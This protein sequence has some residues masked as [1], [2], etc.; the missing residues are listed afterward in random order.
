MVVIEDMEPTQI[1]E[2]VNKNMEK[3]EKFPY[4]TYNGKWTNDKDTDWADGLWIGLL[5]LC[6]KITSDKKYIETA[7]K[8]REKNYWDFDDPEIPDAVKDSFA[9]AIESPGLLT[10]SELSGEE[11]FREDAVNILNSFCDNYLSE[12]DE[13]GILKHDRYHRPENN[14]ITESLIGDYFE[15]VMMK[16]SGSM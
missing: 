5:W 3:L 11:K 4:I 15:E 8:W 6:Y 10:L 9:A 14:R 2:K 1:I 13:D 7:Y 16:I 12:E